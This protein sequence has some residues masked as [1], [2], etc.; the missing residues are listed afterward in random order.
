MRLRL[1]WLQGLFAS[2]ASVA[3]KQLTDG[4]GY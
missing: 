4:I 1:D 3:R 2:E